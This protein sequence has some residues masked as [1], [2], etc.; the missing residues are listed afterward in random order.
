MKMNMVFIAS[1]DA[2][3]SDGQEP[4]T[5]YDSP[6][7]AGATYLSNVPAWP[8]RECRSIRPGVMHMV[9]DLGI[10]VVSRAGSNAIRVASSVL[11]WIRGSN[12]LW[13]AKNLHKIC[14]WLPTTWLR[15]PTTTNTTRFGWAPSRWKPK[16]LPLSSYSITFPDSVM[17][18][19]ITSS[20]PNVECHL[21]IFPT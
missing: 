5:S 9:N 4:N 10:L 3:A 14:A 7:S 15:L 2:H 11:W 18:L 12:L 6:T 19:Q 20:L 21:I 8:T 1:F 13:S 17:Y 16:I